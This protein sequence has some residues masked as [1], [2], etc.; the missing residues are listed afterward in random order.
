LKSFF[1]YL[2]CEAIGTAATPGL[3]EE[4]CF[5]NF[6][7]KFWQVYADICL[8]ISIPVR[9]DPRVE[10]GLNTSTVALRV[11][12]DDEKGSQCLGV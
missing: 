1:F 7:L 3:F 12:E 10:A 9:K 8:Y 4:V 2:V 5:N 6:L 11:V